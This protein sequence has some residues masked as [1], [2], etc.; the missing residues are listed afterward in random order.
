MKN[1]NIKDERVIEQQHKIVSGAFQLV[2]IFLLISVLYK[3]FILNAPFK[4]YMTEFIAF[5]GGSLYVLSVNFMKGNDVYSSYHVGTKKH[6]IRRYLINN[7]GISSGITFGQIMQNHSRD[8]QTPVE[9]LIMFLITFAFSILGS[10]GL[11][12]FSKKRTD[13]IVKQY[14]ERED[15]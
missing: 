12:W 9:I 4:A 11:I 7:L 14:E 2:S 6:R 3:Q 1:K 8:S 5:F 15:N 13:K 10:S